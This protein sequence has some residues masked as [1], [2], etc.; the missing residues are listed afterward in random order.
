MHAH[1][2]YMKTKLA[3]LALIGKYEGRK[4]QRRNVLFPLVTYYI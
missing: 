2:I 3:S 1:N 4:R